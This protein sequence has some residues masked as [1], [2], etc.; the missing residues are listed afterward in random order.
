[1][2]I[3]EAE[4]VV[5]GLPDRELFQEAQYPSGRIPQFLAV[6]EV[7]RRQDM[8][9]RFQAQQQQPQQTVKDQILQGAMGG[10]QP[11]MP[12]MPPQQPPMPQAPA[13]MGAPPPPQAQMYRGGIARMSAGGITKG[14]IVYMQTGRTVP[15]AAPVAPATTPLPDPAMNALSFQLRG[16]PKIM[17]SLRGVLPSGGGYSPSAQQIAMLRPKKEEFIT[18]E[19]QARRAEMISQYE[20][21]VQERLKEDRDLA[22]RYLAEAEAPIAQSQEEA[23]RAAIASTLMRLGSGVASGDAAA[24][25]ASATGAVEDIMGRSREKAEMQRMAAR[26]QAQTA[27][28]EAIRTGRS[29]ADAVFQMQ[30]QALAADTDAQKQFVRSTREFGQWLYGQQAEAGRASAQSQAAAAQIAVSIAG[31]VQRLV[32]EASDQAGLDQRQFSQ[33][34]SN[35]FEN[36]MEGIKDADWGVNSE[37]NPITPTVDQLTSKA[38]ELA[39]KTLANAG[40]YAPSSVANISTEQERK[41]LKKGTVYRGPDGIVRVAN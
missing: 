38:N 23:R 35:V 13:A 2:N 33:T 12:Q 39:N 8:R 22:S 4:D 5:K 37:G 41:A 14:G 6:S 9:Q 20:R 7:Q 31:N 26:Q 19:E 27:E 28:R 30:V 25:L 29:G 1:M 21:T 34:F 16:I 36:V 40:I 10:G 17:E 32:A 11:Q 15:A 3:I 24:G 18:P